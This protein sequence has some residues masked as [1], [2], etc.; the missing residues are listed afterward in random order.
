M[1]QQRWVGTSISSLLWRTKVL[2]LETTGRKSG[3]RRSTPV[4][5]RR[6]DDGDYLVVGG[7]GGQR[8][9]VDWVA[10]LRADPRAEVVVD[11][12]REDVIAD[13]LTG[14]ER[15][16]AW[17]EAR[18]VWPQIDNYERSAGREVPVFR[19]IRAETN[20]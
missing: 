8:T 15:T 2:V 7:A 10:N 5:Y 6:L 19:L 18:K 14:D 16:Q 13:E 20:R 1:L 4:A 17:T 11:R 12:R 3:Q 9:P